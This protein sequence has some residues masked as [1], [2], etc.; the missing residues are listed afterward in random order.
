MGLG[1]LNCSFG[2]KEQT[3]DHIL[4]SC[5]LYHPANGTLGLAALSDGNV[6]WINTTE[7]SI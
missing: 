2:A 5:P 6:D 1:A 3:A 4:A 7:L